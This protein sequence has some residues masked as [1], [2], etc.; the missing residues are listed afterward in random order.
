M[1]PEHKSR[2]SSWLK[3]LRGPKTGRPSQR[4]KARRA[5]FE[6]LEHRRLLVSRV[7]LDFGD[8]FNAPT[9]GPYAGFPA[10]LA[11]NPRDL[12]SA[13]VGTG[14]TPEQH[15]IYSN[16]LG[17]I[18]PGLSVTPPYNIIGTA[19]LFLLNSPDLAH[20]YDPFALDFLTFE[21]AVTGAIQRALE[22]FD[23]QV[24]SSVNST[25]GSFP[26]GGDKTAQLGNASALLA[27]NNQPTDG[28]S[29]VGGTA[30]GPQYG[31][32][33][34]FVYFGGIYQT[35]NNV[36]VESLIP[37]SAN[38]TVRVPDAAGAKPDRLDTG[39]VID[40]NYFI[41]RVTDAGGTGGSLNTAVANAALY[42]IGLGFGLSEVE[43]GTVG[44]NTNFFDPNVA[45]INQANAM[46]EAGFTEGFLASPNS[47]FLSQ[48]IS[49]LASAYFPRFNMMQD[50]V[51]FQPLMRPGTQGNPPVI[52]DPRSFPSPPE[53]YPDFLVPFQT[54]NQN[55]NV[56]VNTYS[57][58]ANDLDIGAN[59]DIQYVTGSGA[60]DKITIAKSGTSQALVTVKAYADSAFT[61]LI[62]TYSYKIN[63][64]K[65]ITAGRRDSG[66]P[67]KVIV[68]GC[69][70]DDQITIDPTLGVNVDV[71]GGAD[72]KLLSITGNGSYNARY[73]PNAPRSLFDSFQTGMDL[74]PET[75]ASAAAGVFQ[76]TGTTKQTVSGKSKNV[77]FTTNI[78]VDH[79]DTANGSAFRLKNFNKLTYASPGFLDNEIVVTA[80]GSGSWQIAGQVDS[81]L[82]PPTL[83]GNLQ[84]NN[85]AQ[86]AFDTTKGASNDIVT[87]NVGNSTPP[88]LKNVSFSLGTG[89]DEL[90][91]DDSAS[92]V[93]QN[94][95]ITPSLVLPTQPQLSPFQGFKYSGVESIILNATQGNNHIVVTPSATTTIDISANDPP[96]GT[97]PPDG[98]TLAIH[99]A[100]TTGATEFDDGSGNGEWDFS[101]RQSV[102]FT[103]IENIIQ[104]TS[105]VLAIGAGAGNKPLAK[106]IDPITGIIQYSFYAYET[107]Y[108]GGVQVA[109]A[110]FDLDGTPDIVV[111]P[112][113]GRKGEV[114]VYS[115]AGLLALANSQGFVSDPSGALL[116]AFNPDGSSYT[117]GLYIAV[118]DIDFDGNPDIVTS[119]ARGT[120]KIRVF[121]NT[122]GAAFSQFSTWQP[123]G[124]SV[125]GGVVVAVAD[126]DGDGLAEVIAAPAAGATANV[127]VFGPTGRTIKQFA[128]FESSFR[129]GVSL[130]AA[131]LDGDGN[132][133]IITG[134]G[135]NG[136]SRV[137]VFDASTGIL[138]SE[139][140]AFTTTTYPLRLTAVD[141][142][143]AGT[144]Q[145]FITRGLSSS[146]Q[147]IRLYDGL[148]G[149]LADR[150]FESTIDFRNGIN[151]G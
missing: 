31:S 7:F 32:D 10:M 23:I 84:F 68:E 72:V 77:A 90:D 15:V 111:A 149:D 148:G 139:F 133:E 5:A 59:P 100:G 144:K 62:T 3:G 69:N 18:A 119:R 63:L 107:S 33:D 95:L 51:D 52:Y 67:F 46:V 91:F 94:Y 12:Y 49:D 120:S 132:A 76:I 11:V 79:F 70:S 123:F 108:K 151:L 34:V 138:R 83:N 135:S 125:G 38:F 103:G 45:L 145:L 134:A 78:A 99:F 106:V 112:G 137:R 147:E 30:F 61:D 143:G 104:P 105:A 22:P 26:V 2:F 65:I 25:F 16:S 92:F 117:N 142:D 47:S 60:F 71:H 101:N 17:I 14:N 42:S 56:T 41:H 98:D 58:L 86:L 85:I 55:P 54:I 44:P 48:P 128:A 93:D 141:P 35:F 36:A 136:G 110:D 114:K 89:T 20:P 73:T 127:K 121:Q 66:Q 24:I 57:Q 87:L 102:L 96:T 21:T 64:K 109:T 53:A 28:G 118:G 129:G 116:T 131:D 9:S 74:I 40:L 27:R 146:Q 113:L 88:G 4:T 6:D 43:N 37:I 75:L 19:G 122:G 126:T 81:P 80:L 97:L 50:G 1:F 8:T 13:L 150:L 140:K 29:P 124:S 39:A 82:V 115:G 130:A